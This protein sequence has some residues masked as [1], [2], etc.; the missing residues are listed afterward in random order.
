MLL[1][2]SS[3]LN[4]PGF[5]M[6]PVA[7]PVGCDGSIHHIEKPWL[8]LSFLLT[9]LPFPEASIHEDFHLLFAVIEF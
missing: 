3:Y 7:V 5:L 9:I 4:L 1:V 8:V 2:Q 6:L